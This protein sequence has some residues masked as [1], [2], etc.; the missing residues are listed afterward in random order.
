MGLKPEQT[1]IICFNSKVIAAVKKACPDLPSYLL[2]GLESAAQEKRTAEQLIAQA[3]EV[4]ADG[5]GL[6]AT[7]ALDSEFAAKVKK[8]GLRLDV[9]TVNDP[10]VAKRVA[11]MVDGITTNRPAWLR[12]QIAK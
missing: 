9:W 6:S 5:L 10:A 11:G 2:V 3:K 8:A 4:M 12:E 1:P 7:D